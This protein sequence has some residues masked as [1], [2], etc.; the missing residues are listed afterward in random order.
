MNTKSMTRKD[1]IT[2]TFT[3]VGSAMIAPA[4]SS[5]S[6]GGGTG[7]SGGGGGSG[8]SGGKGGSGGSG[9]SGGKGGSG[10]GGAG[11]GSGG[12]GGSGGGG[13]GGNTDGGNVDAS[14]CTLPLPEQQIVAATPVDGGPNDT[15]GHTHTVTVNA[16]VLAST[17]AQ[18]VTTSVFV[19]TTAD[20]AHSHD[21]TFM[22]TD[23]ATLR[24]G[25]T[26]EI[27]ST[28][29]ANHTHTYRVS[30][31]PFGDGGADASGQ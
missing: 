27:R 4:C 22:P 8:G 13:A 1:F 18:T 2:L 28:V 14:N 19:S 31:H 25:G 15:N 16:Q 23:L 10:G 17:T 3:L 6:T 21:V 5:S 29:A 9:G 11:G 24:N 30:C 26:V 7:G 12:S 20:A